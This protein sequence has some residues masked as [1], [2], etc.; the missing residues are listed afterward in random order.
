MTS[1]HNNSELQHHGIKGQ[2]WGVR[3]FQ[4]KDGSLTPAGEKRQARLDARRQ[5]DDLKAKRRKRKLEEKKA[6]QDMRED[7]LDRAAQ[8]KIAAKNAKVGRDVAKADA[9]AKNRD[10]DDRYDL[11]DNGIDDAAEREQRAKVGKALAIGALVVVGTAAVAYA[12]KKFKVDP[13]KAKEATEKAAAKAL[14]KDAKLTKKMQDGAAERLK[15]LREKGKVD[16]AKIDKY[17]PD[18]AKATANAAKSAPSVTVNAKSAA[19]AGETIVNSVVG[20]VGG[21][22]MDELTGRWVRS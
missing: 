14:K 7:H 10:D 13:Q 18:I 1:D 22:F 21:L 15:K 20:T 4:N 19:S 3:R 17:F 16:Q 8:R 12:Y 2:R 6:K 9:K 11:P 5:A